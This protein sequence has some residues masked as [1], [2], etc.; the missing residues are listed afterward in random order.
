[1]IGCRSKPR[2]FFLLVAL[3][4]CFS[5]N[6]SL[7]AVDAELQ[8]QITQLDQRYQQLVAQY[9]ETPMLAPQPIDNFEQL[10]TL[11]R[12]TRESQ[13]PLDAIHLLVANLDHLAL[14]AEDPAMIELGEFLLEQNQWQLVERIFKMIEDS[15]DDTNLAYLRFNLA[16]YHSRLNQWQA[17]YD[18]LENTFSELSSDDSDYA[19][20]LQGSALQYLKQHR[21]AIEIYASIPESSKYFVHA[22]LN[23]AIASIRQGWVTE[24][25]LKIRR[26]LPASKA[27]DTEM[28]N[29]IYLVLGYALL[30]KEYYRDARDAFGQIKRDSRYSNKALLGIALTAINQGDYIGGL[31]ILNRLKA[32]KSRELSA[33]EAYLVLPHIYQRLEQDNSIESSF[34]ESIDHYQMRLLELSELKLFLT[35]PEDISLDKHS[36]DIVISDVRL[37]FS[38]HYPFYLLKNRNNLHYLSS[39]ETT[40]ETRAGINRL[41]ADYD[42]TL[43]RV[44]TEIIDKRK[45][46]YSSYLNQSRYGLARHYDESQQGAQ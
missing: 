6:I 40:P 16:K 19:H 11:I 9:Y 13:H 15:G 32:K 23:T 30:H 43:Q 27:S 45:S 18:H 5:S 29:R 2:L 28:T 1:M 26:I 44:L 42:Q 10:V 31:N 8:K 22:Q 34:L 12:S 4:P 21:R 14:S 41:L 17:A 25:R 7:A 46:L 20:L 24:A 37:P 3:L 33:D 38:Q 39:R 36:G 35:K